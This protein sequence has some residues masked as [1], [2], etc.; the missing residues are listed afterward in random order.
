M[1]LLKPQLMV[2]VLLGACGC[3]TTSPALQNLSRYEFK[4]AHMGTL[5]TITLY[6]SNP[7]L[8]ERAAEAGFKRIAA[9]EDTLSDY[10][11][12]SELNLLRDQ[13]PGKPVN[14]STDL[15][16]VLH[17]SQ[18][19]SQ[20]SDGAFDVT[21][22][23]YVR[24]WRF[25]RKR[26]ELPSLA[27]LET[28][29]AAAGYRKLKLDQRAQTVTM[30]ASGMRLD[31]GGM[32]KGYAA[33]EALKVLRKHGI[34]SALIAASGDIALGDA[35]PGQAG[36][37]VGI[38]GI[39]PNTNTVVHT[40]ILSRAGISTS[41]DSEQFVEIAGQR[42][43]HILDPKTGLGLTNRIQATVVAS[44][45]SHSDP[46][47]TAVCILGAKKGTRMIE[48]VPGAAVFILTLEDGEV[49]EFDSSRFK[50]FAKPR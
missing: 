21:M 49:R 36:W 25:A 15:F 18:R 41:G 28:A 1:Q 24:L 31:V 35:P 16:E 34:T 8:A 46:L 50:R 40:L 19:I 14:V 20:L 4:S 9:L 12:D 29:K 27:E 5:F 39:G 13:P 11:A 33:D 45:A 17:H 48:R 38:S 2:A 44:D 37:R 43:S 32:A 3:H 22:G 42:Y 47:A 6:A 23:P 7:A 10:Q 26:K 30:L